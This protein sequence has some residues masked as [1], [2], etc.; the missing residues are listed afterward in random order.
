[1]RFHCP[2]CDTKY[3]ITEDKLTERPTAKMRCKGCATVFSVQEAIA[4]EA[5][6]V[7]EGA[8]P[9]P[10]EPPRGN[11]P[12]AAPPLPPVASG[13]RS[14]PPRPLGP[15]SPLA[16][17]PLAGRPS[18]SLSS[19]VPGAGSVSVR[20]PPATRPL[21]S[22][23]NAPERPIQASPDA[24]SAMPVPRSQ[25]SGVASA[26]PS[27]GSP[28]RAVT[29]PVKGETL[30]VGVPAPPAAVGAYAALG[31]TPSPP[32]GEAAFVPG[33]VAASMGAQLPVLGR[34]SAAGFPPPTAERTLPAV[35]PFHPRASSERGQG[36][37]ERVSSELRAPSP[38]APLGSVQDPVSVV[39]EGADNV[40]TTP[41]FAELSEHGDSNFSSS[42]GPWSSNVNAPSA[43]PSGV[44]A[45]TAPGQAAWGTPGPTKPS[46]ET[47]EVPRVSVGAASVGDLESVVAPSFPSQSLPIRPARKGVSLALAASA[48]VALGA[49]GFASGYIVGTS[50]GTGPIANGPVIPG[51]ETGARLVLTPPPPPPPDLDEPASAHDVA[52]S[53]GSAKVDEGGKRKSGESRKTEET[54]G[55]DVSPQVE[56]GPD[57]LS[58]LAVAPGPGPVVGPSSPAANTSAGLEA[59]AI[60]GTVHRY[61]NAVKRS[62]WQPALNGRSVDA[63]SSARVTTT[64]QILPNGSVASV[65]HTGDPRG[66][67]GLASCIATRLKG[68]TFPK[69]NGT[70]TANIPFVFA[71]Q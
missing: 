57:T 13:R 20:P 22:L 69:S 9:D 70:T 35:P 26:L 37:E 31:F 17:T 60:Q 62:C 50:A 42:S 7:D 65:K 14:S 33:S 3:R 40:G 1:M 67:P 24:G 61:Q 45:G 56:S 23:M 36:S 4:A 68:W 59:E 58:A 55:S 43:P 47:V 39:S 38:G 15:P 44:V 29:L 28:R 16:R 51:A 52:Q 30:T 11:R 34:G 41:R 21:G 54:R 63:P 25:A 5:Q 48:A 66:Y 46:L 10:D 2:K 8:Q 53:P 49:I 64:I 27:S 18:T 19:E 32:E 6:R 71:A 12:S